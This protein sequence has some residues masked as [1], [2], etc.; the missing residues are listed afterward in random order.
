MDERQ[1]NTPSW[2]AYVCNG[3]LPAGDAVTR[4]CTGA[5]PMIARSCSWPSQPSTKNS[6]ELRRSICC[7]SISTKAAFQAASMSGKREFSRCNQ[8]RAA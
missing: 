8:S 4:N 7:R 5:S 3:A 6:G 1:T 2:P